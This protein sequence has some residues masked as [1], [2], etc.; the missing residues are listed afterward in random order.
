MAVFNV[1]HEPRILIHERERGKLTDV[2]VE[3]AYF[4]VSIIRKMYDALA[5]T[6]GQ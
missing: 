5:E 3:A 2:I 4:N 6:L 1:R